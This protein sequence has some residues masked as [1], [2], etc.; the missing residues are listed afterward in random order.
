V[1]DLFDQG[2]KNAPCIVFIDEIDAVGRHRFAG[3]GGGHDERE[4]TL[5]QLLVEMDGFNA[6]EGVIIIAAT[7]RPDVLDPALMRA[8]RFDRQIN[9]DVPD[10]SGREA[11]FKVHTENIVLSNDV[12]MKNLARRTPGFSGADIANC[13]NEAALL[14]ARRSK[15]A[16]DKQ[17]FEDAID[18]VMA[19]PEKKSKVMSEKEKKVIAYHEAGHALMH[20]FLDDIDPLHKVSILPRGQALGY[21]M[22]LPMDDKYLTGSKEMLSMITSLLG[23]RV[24]EAVVFNEVTTGAQNDL[25]RVTQIAHRM[26]CEFGMSE[27][28]GPMSFGGGNDQQVF[29][30]RDFGRVRDY[31]EDIAFEIDKEVRR[32]VDECYSRCENLLRENIEM[33][34]KLGNALLEREVLDRDEV[35]ELLGL[36]K[37]EDQEPSE[38]DTPAPAADEEPA[39]ERNKGEEPG[40]FPPPTPES[41]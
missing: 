41:I 26:V 14:A 16:V 19:G 25:Q 9:V 2:K 4:Q 3:I 6:N 13:V 27:R 7:N 30:G 21:T 38:P 39:D 8:G 17:D 15:D 10:L 33:L 24:S 20:L 40:L 35:D 18:R 36:K 1:R 28:L 34:H 12:N 11:I 32:I 37:E 23:G 31:S 29:L 22:H 5:N